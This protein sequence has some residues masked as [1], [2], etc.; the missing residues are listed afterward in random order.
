[1][2]N[3][4][5][6]FE[7]DEINHLLGSLKR[8]DAPGDFDFRVRARIATGRPAVGATWLPAFGKAAAMMLLLAAVAG[9]FGFRS[10]RSAVPDQASVISVPALNDETVPPKDEVAS[11]RKAIPA[12]SEQTSDPVRP[13]ETVAQTAPQVAS[14]R[15]VTRTGSNIRGG[16]S[17][18]M[19]QRIANVISDP[20]STPRLSKDNL[21]ALGVDASEGGSGWT[22]GEVKQNSRAERSGLKAGDVIEAVKGNTVRV[23][24]GGKVVAVK[25]KP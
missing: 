20:T 10:S 15:L 6:N 17:R 13:P 12:V 23:R 9:Y 25:L 8:V 2:A 1:M 22:V 24:R 18:D 11:D 16:G 4:E 14:N 19:T 21:S 3:E 5:N 7:N